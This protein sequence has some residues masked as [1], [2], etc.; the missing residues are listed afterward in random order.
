MLNFNILK[1]KKL[2]LVFITI[3]VIAPFAVN[4]LML[5]SMPINKGSVDSWIGFFG[6]YFGGTFSSL[7]GALI[8]GLLAIL[9]S[10][11]QIS[12]QVKENEKIA[13]LSRLADEERIRKELQLK[14]TE[15]ITN[16]ISH[17]RKTIF[18]LHS[19][20]SSIFYALEKYIEYD[21][22]YNMNKS[23]N[24]LESRDFWITEFNNSYEKFYKTKELFHHDV[25]SFQNIYLSRRVILHNFTESLELVFNDIHELYKI[26]IEL[27]EPLS[28]IQYDVKL[29][30]SLDFDI[31]NSVLELYNN[32]ALV[33]IYKVYCSIWEMDTNIQNEFLGPL[34][35]S[36]VQ[37]RHEGTEYL[38]E[39]I[40]LKGQNA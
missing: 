1:I 40:V 3:W 13:A 11:E 28:F 6:N 7:I 8:G 19:D 27:D 14:T 30:R 34:F 32:I 38:F 33:I 12:I 31:I 9:I 17:I 39:K 2:I 29:Y 36:L 35:N 26:Y 15:L 10:R 16:E 22:L 23:D 25:I 4:L 21:N 20:F 18:S 37:S 5:F 24:D